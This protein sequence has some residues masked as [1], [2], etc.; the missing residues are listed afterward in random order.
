MQKAL[1]YFLVFVVVFSLLLSACAKPNET[2]PATSNAQEVGFYRKVA[3]EV[4]ADGWVFTFV[5]NGYKDESIDDSDLIKYT[6]YGINLRY[7]YDER[8]IQTQTQTTDKGTTVTQT[9]VPALLIWGQGSDAQSRDMS[10]I[11][12]ILV[13]NHSVD[14]LLA[15]DPNDYAFEE[16][17]KDMFFRL[18]RQALTGE[19]QKEGTEQSYW[20]KPTYA[21]FTEP[22]YVEEYKFQV[23]FLQETGCVDELYI[24]VLYRTGDDYNSYTQL[25]DLV[26]SGTATLEQKQAFE[27]IQDI[28][29]DIKEHE[30]YIINADK[31]QSQVVAGI[32]FS[33]LYT[34]LKNIHENNYAM[35]YDKPI[36]LSSERND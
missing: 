27:L 20:D 11:D 17:N 9:Y 4:C 24:D 3:R 33:R 34:F 15:L 10:I 30:N 28:V 12:S 6:F 8:F 13:N 1:A 26:D 36:I 2:N 31:Y 23:A 19:P 16:L 32:D 29:N 5:N 25:S 21:F 7:K 22:A 18:M 35:Y 14:D